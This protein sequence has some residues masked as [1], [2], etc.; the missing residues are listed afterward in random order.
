MAKR[1]GKVTSASVCLEAD[2]LIAS[3]QR[4]TVPAI[5]EALGG[6]SPTT[7]NEH[8]T[9]W[10]R[11]VGQRIA[12]PEAF[13]VRK[14]DAPAEIWD[15]CEKLWELALDR[16]K[17]D[18]NVEVDGRVRTSG[19]QARLALE[20]ARMQ[21]GEKAALAERLATV[22]ADLSAERARLARRTQELTEARDTI[23]T[24]EGSLEQAHVTRAQ[25]LQAHAAALST[26]KAEC[27]AMRKALEEKRLELA[28]AIDEAKTRDTELRRAS[29]LDLDRER[30]EKKT[31]QARVD[32][33]TE[34]LNLARENAAIATANGASLK[35][36][37]QDADTRSAA[38]EQVWTSRVDEVT[39]RAVA[40]EARLVE[41]QEMMTQR[42]LA[43]D[44]AL[45][46]LR[47]IATAVASSPTKSGQ[48]AA[49][50][51]QAAGLE[52]AEK[53]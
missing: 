6:G 16:S 49:R 28:S 32:R 53:P 36:R 13:G 2:R 24:V 51:V 35:S 27:D 18:Y 22:E 11:S 38:A 52:S 30:T 19:E 3:G 41:H 23:R 37:L 1:T 14:G 47:E 7:I 50:A 17:A 44:Q 33:L 25:D 31:A 42:V 8:L 9:D 20:D 34:D 5:R 29:M 48:P 39:A 4:P 26:A 15:L 45:K 21:R 43:D 46:L 12:N 40:A 10:F